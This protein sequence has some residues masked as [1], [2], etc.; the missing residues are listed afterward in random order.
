MSHMFGQGFWKSHDMAVETNFRVHVLIRTY[1]VI[2]AGK[3][4]KTC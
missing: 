4:Q 2:D 3:G 1:V